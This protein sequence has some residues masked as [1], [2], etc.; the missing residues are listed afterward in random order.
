[1]PNAIGR[2]LRQQCFGPTLPMLLAWPRLAVA[3]ETPCVATSIQLAYVIICLFVCFLCVCVCVCA[4]ARMC[5]CV[6]V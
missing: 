4:R 1:M 5:V 2:L 6:C 3:M